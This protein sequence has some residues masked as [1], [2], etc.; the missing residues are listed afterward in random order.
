MK[1][2]ARFS[3]ETS[4]LLYGFYCGYFSSGKSTLFSANLL[5]LC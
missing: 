1:K 5:D 4:R 2:E 3:L